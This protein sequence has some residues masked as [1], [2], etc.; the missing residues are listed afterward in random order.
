MSARSILAVIGLLAFASYAAYATDP[1]QLQDFCVGVNDPKNA[2]NTLSIYYNF[3]FLGHNN[4]G[5]Q[6]KA[7]FQ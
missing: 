2:C 7:F 4:S 3:G 5:A 1:T 6:I